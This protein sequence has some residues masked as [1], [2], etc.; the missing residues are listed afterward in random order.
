MS[1]AGPFTTIG[2]AITTASSGDTISVA[3]GT[4][5][6]C[7]DTAGKNLTIF[8]AGTTSTVITAGS[9]CANGIAVDNGES[10]TLSDLT[11]THPS[12]RALY[13]VSSSLTLSAVTVSASGS[14]S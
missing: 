9:T 10:V 3:A 14:T 13:V 6:E 11:V 1:S 7:L 5:S 12:Y 2:A 4:W 8:G